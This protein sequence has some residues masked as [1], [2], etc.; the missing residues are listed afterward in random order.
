MPRRTQREIAQLVLE[1][2]GR[3]Y[4]HQAGL[5]LADTPAA[6]YQ[7]LVL[8]VL[9]SARISADIAVAL[10]VS[11]STPVAGRPMRCPPRPGRT[12][13]TPWGADTTGATTNERQRCWEKAR[14]LSWNR[15]D[16][17]LRRLAAEADGDVPALR[18][19][20]EEFP[21]IGPVGA[22]I[23]CREAQAV[24]PWLRPYAD[25][26]ALDGAERVGLPRD[27]AKLA[28]LVDDNQQADFAAGLVRI[29]LLR[30]GE[31][32]LD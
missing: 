15:W 2:H 30:A 6:L 5:Q 12:A 25:D 16:G 23:Y 31:D 10:P 18:S 8:S 26:R 32:P 22:D 11:C 27:A 3:T 20:L 4:A 14:L 29:T 28:R 21:G 19:M 1:R 13:S 9:L 7:L 24:W 17:D